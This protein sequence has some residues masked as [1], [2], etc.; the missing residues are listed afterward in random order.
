MRREQEVA[1]SSLENLT[2]GIDLNSNI[3]TNSQKATADVLSLLERYYDRRGEEGVQV[4]R[5][6]GPDDLYQEDK[7]C[8]DLKVDQGD[9]VAETNHDFMLRYKE[10]R[11]H[12]LDE[13]AAARWDANK[14]HQSCKDAGVLEHT[15]SSSTTSGISDLRAKSTDSFNEHKGSIVPSMLNLNTTPDTFSEI[16]STPRCK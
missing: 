2:E 3:S 8:R 10:Q 4:E 6:H 14:L 16:P 12:I 9:E 7:I 1:T 15:K 13:L 11:Q 5:L